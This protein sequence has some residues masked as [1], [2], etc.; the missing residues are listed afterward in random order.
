MTLK[1][2]HVYFLQALFQVSDNFLSTIKIPHFIMISQ[3]CLDPVDPPDPPDGVD[4]C[5][6]YNDN[7]CCGAPI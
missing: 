4:V 7:C 6:L 2:H 1:I 3:D 5:Q